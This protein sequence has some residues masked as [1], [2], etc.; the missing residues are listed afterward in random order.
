MDFVEQLTFLSSVESE[1]EKRN[2]EYY[3][4]KSNYCLRGWRGIDVS[5]LNQDKSGLVPLTD[6]DQTAVCICNG[7]INIR[8]FAVTP[9]LRRAVHRLVRRG[10]AEPCSYG[11][12]LTE[13]QKMR[14]VDMPYRATAKWAITGRCNMKCKH[15]FLSAP[16]AKFG[17]LTHEECMKL[18][19]EM[20]EAGISRIGL[21]GGEPLVRPDFFEIVDALTERN[22]KVVGIATNGLLLNERFIGQLEDRGLK[23]KIFMSYDGT[24]GWHD[25]LRGID[26]AEKMLLQKFE[27]LAKHDFYTGSAMTI[28]KLNKGV[29]RDSVNLLASVGVKHVIVNRMTNFGEWEKYGQD[30]NITAKELYD[31]FFAYLPHFYED[32][33]PVRIVLN[34]F[35]S[36]AAPGERDY[37][38]MPVKQHKNCGDYLCLPTH[39]VVYFT[40]DGYATPC[41]YVASQEAPCVQLPNIKAGLSSALTDPNYLRMVDCTCGDYFE[42]NPSC[43]ECEYASLC[44]GGCRAHALEYNPNDYMAKDYENCMFYHENFHRRIY[45][46]IRQIA[47]DAKCINYDPTKS[48][49]D[50]PCSCCEHYS[51]AADF[52]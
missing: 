22:I 29:I 32:G 5:L 4:L 10:I 30:F 46:L 50:V 18:I 26:G 8:N 11:T 15:C 33:A 7:K 40:A 36:T 38:I 1:E 13:L 6:L 16:D 14:R 39:N 42:H 28:H 44:M 31:A 35:F 25:W 49:L 52:V 41:L 48:S 51:A 9:V 27:L 34:R 47:P 17:E 2:G 45:D 24:D 19:D 43:K 21:T 20:A 12:E 3:I 23:P 37:T